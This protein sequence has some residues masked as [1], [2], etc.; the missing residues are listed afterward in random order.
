MDKGRQVKQLTIHT[1]QLIEMTNAQVEALLIENGFDLNKPIERY[2]ELI[3]C[4]FI[5]RQ[6]V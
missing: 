6:E 4:S 3:T 1:M 5:F 2:D